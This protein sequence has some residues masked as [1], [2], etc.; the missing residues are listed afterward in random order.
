MGLVLLIFWPP[1][2]QE[3]SLVSQFSVVDLYVLEITGSSSTRG[4]FPVSAGISW[5]TGLLQDFWPCTNTDEAVT[6]EVSMKV[7]TH[8]SSHRGDWSSSGMKTACNCWEQ[9]AHLKSAHNFSDKLSWPTV[10]FPLR[11][12]SDQ[13]DSS[14]HFWQPFGED[15][16]F[17]T[18]LFHYYLERAMSHFDFSSWSRD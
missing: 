3:M 11:V 10:G 7:S 14:E 17:F 6:D 2:P 16:S 4:L 18:E 15:S 12:T 1:S 9:L 13:H 8:V 5:W